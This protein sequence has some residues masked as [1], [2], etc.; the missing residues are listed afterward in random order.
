MRTS[1]LR[2]SQIDGTAA[3]VVHR[4]RTLHMPAVLRAF[5]WLVRVPQPTP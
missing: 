3:P 2:G 4:A 5:E 1:E